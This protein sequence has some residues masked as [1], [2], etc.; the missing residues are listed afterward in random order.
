MNNL[1]CID[2][3]STN[4]KLYITHD[5]KVYCDMKPSGRDISLEVFKNYIYSFL[6]GSNVSLNN[7]NG[8]AVAFPGVANSG[9]V[10]KSC[11]DILNH[12]GSAFL[13]ELSDKVIYINDA[14]AAAIYT[15]KENPEYNSISALTV[16]TN[17]GFSLINN[18]QLFQG[19]NNNAGEHSYYTLLPNGEFYKLG[20]FCSGKSIKTLEEQGMSL[21]QALDTTA[22][23]LAC[24]ITQVYNLYDP[25]IIFLSGGAFIHTGFF[26]LVE[27]YLSQISPCKIKLAENAV[28]AGCLGAKYYWENCYDKQLIT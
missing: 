28:Y 22:K 27:N 2:L 16:G 14:N 11:V 15:S 6:E 24:L 20:R 9:N 18:G 3:G 1:L 25:D 26:E 8:I 21:D 13:S 23:H 19:G 17:I 5:N 12:S 10:V 4:I 7:L